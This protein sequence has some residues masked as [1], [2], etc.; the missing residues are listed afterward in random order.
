M[1]QKIS[2]R[3]TRHNGRGVFA[4][5]KIKKGEIIEIA[6][7]IV[8][9]QREAAVLM[10]LS[11]STHLYKWG[12]RNTHSALVLGMCCFYNHSYE[13]NAVCYSFPKT[14]SWV[15][16]ALK[17]IRSGQEITFNYNGDPKST[18]PVCFNKDGGWEFGKK[19]SRQKTRQ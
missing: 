16:R 7:V 9:S 1:R 10:R 12:I 18:D 14:K 11:L 5:C 2:V 13:P 19:S 4:N 17:D 3:M 8:F 6:P 15:F